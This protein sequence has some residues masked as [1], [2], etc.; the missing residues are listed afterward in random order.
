MSLLIFL[1]L[2]LLLML[3]LFFVGVYH[4]MQIDEKRKG[5]AARRLAPDID[6]DGLEATR[7]TEGDAAAIQRLMR[8]AE[9]DPFTA[10]AALDGLSNVSASPHR[11]V[12]K[13]R[14]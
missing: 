13:L 2:N 7:R 5:I 3:G 10:R 1:A 11:D 8:E 6:L 4:F 14:Q 12:E 9:L